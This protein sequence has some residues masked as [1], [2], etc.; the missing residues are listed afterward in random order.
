MK[1]NKVSKGTVRKILT[2]V[3]PYYAGLFL[4]FLCAALTVLLT[5]Y[6]PIAVGDAIDYIIEP[7]KV[8]MDF[9]ISILIRVVIAAV[10]AALIQWIQGVINNKI[11]FGIVRNLRSAAFDK[12]QQLPVSYSDTNAHGDIVSRIITDA[13]QF[14]DGLLMGFS[15][16][17]TGLITIIGTLAF[18]FVINWK[19]ALVV[20]LVTP[21]SLFVASFIA[22][23]THNLFSSQAKIRG[24]QTAYINESIGNEK[25]VR[26]Y[27]H[28]TEAIETFESMNKE[29]EKCSLKA[30][31]FS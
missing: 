26:A 19:I 8:H 9:I 21:L 15:Q 7:G 11:T 12:L 31:F 17:F 10:L 18:M 22:S 28:E 24:E 27:G 14:S 25:V 2:Y 29:L 5:L 13:D 30:V 1:K 3:R 20:V 6:I 23:R 16:L 4:S